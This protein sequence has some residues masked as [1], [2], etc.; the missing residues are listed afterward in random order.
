M[1][2]KIL[3]KKEKP[4][5]IK[6]YM[7]KHD[8][9]IIKSFF[10]KNEISKNLYLIRKNL[11]KELKEIKLSGN[12]YFNR[13]NYNRLDCGSF[14]QV[15]ARFCRML[16]VFDWNKSKYFE[17]ILKDLVFLR[18]EILGLKKNKHHIYSYKNKKF[19]NLKKILHYPV[20]GGFMNKHV[21]S[22]NNEGYPNFLVH[23]TKRGKENFQNG[24]S[25]YEI[26]KKFIDVENIL[27]PGDVYAH[28]IN[29]LHGVSTIDINKKIDIYNL[30]LGRWVINLSLEKLI[31]K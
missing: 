5:K 2:I 27:E 16:A 17:K 13:K 8:V 4:N 7:T 14:N 28:S 12:N 9:I 29:T 10:D 26:N 15:N 18:D 1:S 21:D 22:F 31:K 11:F 6:S 19:Y 24:G 20:G 30:N 3:S 23:L 25:Y